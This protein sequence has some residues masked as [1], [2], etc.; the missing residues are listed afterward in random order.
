MPS[1]VYYGPIDYVDWSVAIVV[2]KQSMW[3][4]LLKMS[5][6]L[7]LVVAIGM[8]MVWLAVRKLGTPALK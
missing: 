7:L 8:L 5:L 1:T 4:P 2:A 3:G 6:V